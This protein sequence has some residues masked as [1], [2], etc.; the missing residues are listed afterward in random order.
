MESS[1]LWFQLAFGLLQP[2]QPLP[3][4][5]DSA[6]LPACPELFMVP[7][8]YPCK[9]EAH[10]PAIVFLIFDLINGLW[11]TL[12]FIFFASEAI[13]WWNA[14]WWPEGQGFKRKAV[15]DL[16]LWLIKQNTHALH[17]IQGGGQEIPQFIRAG[18]K[19]MAS[20][21]GWGEWNFK[22]HLERSFDLQ[23]LRGEQ[24]N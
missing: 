14:L 16:Q 3:I 1:P 10:R 2:P 24:F 4:L 11:A 23:T 12:G 7:S 19:Q 22:L 13:V 18:G 6:P 21:G 9:R 20:K 17:E 5:S 8:S 15:K